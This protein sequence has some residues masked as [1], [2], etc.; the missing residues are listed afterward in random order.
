[1]KVNISYSVELGEVLSTVEKLYL[2]AKE[3]FDV[4]QQEAL[5]E[6]VPPFT[7]VQ[8]QAVLLAL[9][10]LRSSLT[11]FDAKLEEV[12]RLLKSYQQIITGDEPQRPSGEEDAD[13]SF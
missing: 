9:H 4:R 2:E 13:E 3:S 12:S 10:Q 7:D 5:A 6:I 11:E 8:L 1:M